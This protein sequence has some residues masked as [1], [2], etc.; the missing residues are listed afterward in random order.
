MA[1]PV[2]E[3]INFVEKGNCL[4]FESTL[5]GSKAKDSNDTSYILLKS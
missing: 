4:D 5:C 3:I 1:K 2:R